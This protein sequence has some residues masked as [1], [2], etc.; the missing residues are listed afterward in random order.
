MHRNFSRKR[1]GQPYQA[2]PLDKASLRAL[3]LRYVERYATTQVNLSRYLMRKISERGWDGSQH[4]S[5]HVEELVI[6]F[7]E[8]S[9]VNDRAVAETKARASIRKGLGTRRLVQDI[10]AA[11]ISKENSA[12]ALAEAS[13]KALEAAQNFAKKKGIGAYARNPLPDDREQRQKLKQKQLQAF[14]RAGHDFELARRFV[15]G[16]ED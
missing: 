15:D 12:D 8:L 6:Q 13:E 1:G 10:Y 16:I 3:A 11:G 4:F 14:L 9:Y 5:Q 7:A 2:P